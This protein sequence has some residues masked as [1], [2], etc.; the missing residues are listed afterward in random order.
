M[1]FI[2]GKHPSMV[3]LSSTPQQVMSQTVPFSHIWYTYPIL[4]QEVASSLSLFKQIAR[5]HSDF[6]EKYVH[7]LGY[8]K[9]WYYSK[10]LLGLLCFAIPELW[11][12]QSTF[13]YSYVSY[14]LGGASHFQG[15][16]VHMDPGLFLPTVWWRGPFPP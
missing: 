3:S 14:H 16:F 9:Y 8:T 12:A 15:K 6:A 2:N 1:S 5:S 10:Y 13:R 4:T 11:Y 7:I